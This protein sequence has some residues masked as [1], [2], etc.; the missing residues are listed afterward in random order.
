V[1]SAVVSANV[2]YQWINCETNSP[3]SGAINA[4]FAATTDGLYAVVIT[5]SVCNLSDTSSCVTLEN[6]SL[7]EMNVSDFITVYPNP[8]SSLLYI[9]ISETFIGKRMDVIDCFGKVVYSASLNT[10]NNEINLINLATGI[11]HVRIDENPTLYRIVK[12]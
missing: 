6:V 8:V 4:Q 10:V 12:M 11:Y 1:L 2:T 9:S 3:I 7:D 5:N